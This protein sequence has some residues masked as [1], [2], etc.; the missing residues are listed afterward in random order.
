MNLIR[1]KGFILSRQTIDR[2]TGMVVILWL[3]TAQGPVKLEIEQE[4]A[5]FFISQHQQAQ[6]QALLI[7]HKIT[8]DK[9]TP[10]ALK[11]FSQQPLSGMYFNQ[12]NQFYAA[13]ELLTG[14]GIKCFEDD[15]RPD[16]RFLMERYITAGVEF[17]G[18]ETNPKHQ[19]SV[20]YPPP[21]FQRITQA[22]CRAADFHQFD[23]E[24]SM[25]SIDLECSIK[26]QLYSIGLYSDDIEQVIMIGHPEPDSPD[27]I[28]WVDD[29][30][31]L[32]T[33]FIESVQQCDPDIFIGWN[34]VNF[35]FDLLQKRCDLHQIVFAI[36]RDQSAPYWRGN[37]ANSSGT[38]SNG[39]RYI[40]ISGRVVLDG[41]D[42]MKNAT[43][44][45]PSF[46]LDNVA[47]EILGIGKHIDDVDNRVQEITEKFHRNKQAL[48]DYNLQ[49]CRLVWQIF[50]QTDL[51][52]FAK[53]RAHLTGL[54]IDRAGGSVASFI[55]LYVPKLHRAGYVAP[56]MGDGISGL[57]SPG[58]YVMD[59][60]PGLYKNVLVLDFKSLYPSIIRTFKI[61]PMGL[62]E[63]LKAPEQAIEGFD[64]AYFSRDQHFLP[65]IITELWGERDKAKAQNNAVLSQAIKIIMNSFY[66]IL[67]STGCRFFDPRLSGS[68][69]KRSH[70]LLKTT[71]SWLEAKGYQVI[72]G[73]TDSIF[74]AIGD[75]YDQGQSRA[76]GKELETYINDKWRRTIEHEFSLTSYL[77]IEFETHFQRFLM[78]TVRGLDIGTK[79]RYAGLIVEQQ[80]KSD[81]KEQPAE[82]K[83]RMVFKGLESVRS[84]WTELAKVFQH[85]L[86][87]LVFNDKP[88]S[89]ISEYVETMVNKTLAG[90]HDHLLIYRKRIRRKL[91]DYVKN[92]PPHVKAARLADELNKKQGKPLKY[93]YRGNIAYCLTTQGPQTVE[94]LSAPLDYQ[95]YIERQLKA[96]ADAILPFVGTSFDQITDQQLALF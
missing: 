77:E 79:K 62:I 34:V 88:L 68:I 55:N 32:L 66:G 38:N 80:G 29:E 24:L 16:E 54:A 46:A 96:V 89:E 35:D 85:Q 3:R 17:Q 69:T 73:D 40:N 95:L 78:P 5:V 11:N 27:Y 72:Y 87:H 43:Y 50:E 91:A 67:G 10:L 39:Q 14:A 94:Y 23:F 15:F 28:L 8:L 36:G 21:R 65:D 83:Q 47:N 18:L 58:G 7:E 31:A 64:G 33:A 26:G 41:I 44:N 92:V 51:L 82:A 45:F 75:E 74:V 93:Q 19:S 70:A 1:N 52:A 53:L 13:R 20:A 56:N 57:V 61:D 42:M 6:A 49:D 30:K 2:G 12:L 63:G 48:A 60:I 76:I 9:V 4:Q 81:T 84:D 25:L 90:E 22:K 37:R 71:Q 59:S 86:Y